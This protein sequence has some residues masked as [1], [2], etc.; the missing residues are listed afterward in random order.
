MRSRNGAK[1]GSVGLLS[2][3]YVNGRESVASTSKE[4]SVV[5]MIG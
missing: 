2:P 4:G 5:G 1:L 3:K